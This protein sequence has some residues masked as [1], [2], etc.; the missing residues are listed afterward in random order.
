[1]EGQQLSRAAHVNDQTAARLRVLED[2]RSM[3]ETKLHKL[4]GE[5]NAL[6]IT[7]D[8]LRKDKANVRHTYLRKVLTGWL[9]NR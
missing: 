8:G 3:L 2:E 6:E 7:R 5:L 1:M 9:G 4:E